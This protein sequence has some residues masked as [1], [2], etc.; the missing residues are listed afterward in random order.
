M[1]LPASAADHSPVRDGRSRVVISAVRADS[2]R[3]DGRSERRDGRSD[4]S[5]NRNWVEVSNTGRREV[6]LDRWT[7]SDRDGHVFTFHHFRLEGRSTVRIHSGE[8]RGS[9]TDLYQ[10]RR[11]YVWDSGSDTAT[12]RDSHGR[13]VDD[14]SWGRDRRD[15]DR[16][17]GDDRDHRDDMRR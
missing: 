16:R 15:G 5:L 1:A 17:H 8:G 9:R 13:F 11:T 12:L 10:G 3:R 4:R 7:L 14:A 6:N 2:P